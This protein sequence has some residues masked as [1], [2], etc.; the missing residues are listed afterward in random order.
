M[1][2]V[3]RAVSMLL[4]VAISAGVWI[5]SGSASG[6]SRAGMVRKEYPPPDHRDEGEELGQSIGSLEPRFSDSVHV[7]GVISGSDAGGFGGGISL[8][9]L[10]SVEWSPG[11]SDKVEFRDLNLTEREPPMS[12]A[13]VDGHMPARRRSYWP[14]DICHTLSQT[15]LSL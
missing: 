5:V 9:V 10:P 2:G 4:S 3:A 12:E 11:L 1:R 6:F 8:P 7:C 14:P 15:A 13:W